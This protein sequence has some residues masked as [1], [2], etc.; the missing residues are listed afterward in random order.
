MGA[1]SGASLVIG[2]MIGG[3]IFSTP[4]AI[5]ALVGGPVPNM[6]VWVIGALISLLGAFSY[7]EL[8]SM[9][10]K[11]G[12]EQVYLSHAFRKPR[13]LLAF[14]FCFCIILAIRPSCAA[15]VSTVFGKYILYAAVGPAGEPG[16]AQYI[17]DHRGWIERG[18]GFV[19]LTSLAVLNALSLKWAVRVNNALSALK[20]LTLLVIA[21]SG[22]VVLAGATNVPRALD[23][24]RLGFRDASSSPQHWASAMFKILF[25]YDGW[26]N[27][28]YALGE[29]KNPRRNLPLA[30][31]GGVSFTVVLYI[32]ANVAYFSVVP[33]ADIYTSKEILAGVYCRIVFGE[34]V[35]RIIL[36]ILVALSCYGCVSSIMFGVYRVIVVA[37]RDRYMPYSAFFAQIHPRFGTP[38]NAVVITYVLS[39][40]YMLAPPPGE[41]FDF[42]VDLES[43]PTW[44]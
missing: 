29:L 4:S 21:I 22:I 12:G 27:L 3:G 34:T 28:N 6:L 32:L 43:Y 35:G 14:M 31:G 16:T 10:P 38:F 13:A 8:G 17:V 26:S 9:I 39:A 20:V 19:G 5:A 18:I 7:I 2:M 15:A 41:V 42:L 37:A 23:N 11:S 33:L 40:V 44:L 30:V 24:W 1:L 36:P 25:A